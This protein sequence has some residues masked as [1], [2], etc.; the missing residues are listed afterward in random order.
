[1]LKYI[2]VSH[3]KE[4]TMQINETIHGFK[5]KAAT[6]I[7]EIKATL[8]ECEHLKS[9]ARLFFLDREDENKTFSIAF[10]T[11]PTDST[12]VFHIIEHAVL[13]GSKKYPVKE[14]FVELLKGSLNTFLNAMTFSDKTMYPVASRNDKDFMNLTSVY[15]DAVFHP[16]ILENPNIFRQEGWHL[17]L[18]EETGEL[19]RSGV[20]LNEMRGAFSSP[21]DLA[22]YHICEMLYPDTCYRYESGGMPT[23]IPNLT[24]EEFCAAHRKY[25][26]PS[27]AEI[28][29]DGSVK[30]DEVLP[31]IDEVLSEYER[32]NLSFEIPDQKPISP[33]SK[34]VEY[35]ISPTETEK[36][37]TRVA[38]GYLT[39]RFDEQE[40]TVAAEVLID[41]LASTNESPL[42][43]AVMDSRLCEDMSISSFDSIK[44]NCVILEFLNVSDKKEE[45]LYSLFEESVKRIASEGIESE[46]LE[47]SLSRLEFKTREKDHGTLP[48]GIIY[49]ISILESS[50]YGGNPAQNLSYEL[51][52]KSL[53]EKLGTGYFEKL[54]T[55]IFIDN[56]HRA[57]LT[58]L[59]S[60]TLG[61]KRARAE[62]EELLSLKNSMSEAELK[63]VTVAD[64]DLKAWQQSE[65]SP[66]ALLTIPQLKI[67]DISDEVEKIPT[68]LTEANGITVLR[69]GVPT[70][71]IV[72]TDLYFDASDLTE[73]EIFD[74]R[75]L[76]SLIENVRTHKHEA[77]ELQNTVKGQLGAL[78]FSMTALTKKSGAKIYLNVSASALETKKDK[79]VE[80][81]PEI[82]YTS[83]Y[84]DKEICHNILRQLKLASEESFTSSGHLAA[85]RRA[86]SYKSPES[87]IQEYYA[88]YEALLS[89]KELEKNFDVEFDGL[90]KRLSELAKR[91]FTKER[92]TVAICASRDE[93]FEKELTSVIRS[94]EKY[95][96][97]SK[98]QPL[99]ARREGIAVPSQTSYAALAAD[100]FAMNEKRRGSIIVAR[101]ILSYGYLWNAVRVQG[102]AYGV[103]LISRNNGSIGFYSY[104]DPTPARTLDCFKS[105]AESL[106]NVARGGEDVTKFIIGA[107]GETTPLTTPKLKT[108]LAATRFLRGVSYEDECKM[109]REILTTDSKELMKIADILDKICS[110]DCICIVGAKEKID[111]VKGLEQILQI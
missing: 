53:R 58:M 25:Y 104:R 94:G 68:E 73:K 34:T 108:T 105:A 80:I 60:S 65:D 12:G 63:E 24:Y 9:G 44:Q 66:E 88:G 92:L 109:R 83:V 23:D 42:K 14:P 26:H 2:V 93:K 5:V 22:S 52:F 40:R 91:L 107:I 99:G 103:G 76:I 61:E 64:E 50:L 87:A 102:G 31:L 15:L 4:N 89:I 106:R 84:T 49:A 59:P 47:A 62:G 56:T 75:M 7:K 111:T 10:K 67:S 57:T 20:V 6:E 90:A 86:A 100:L 38:V 48:I 3:R 72:Y 33:I 8:F 30:L 85:F 11:I 45:E 1:M 18:D 43:K 95:D 71:G 96:P 16:A 51:S 17:E 55:E 54:L 81:L 69:V 13:C 28:F 37:K 77:I 98:I 97:V 39:S 32:E 19:T 27:N 74:F 21:D 29:L 110:L 46:L 78:S 35:E 36:D 101:S 82:L 70:A 79:I 41:A